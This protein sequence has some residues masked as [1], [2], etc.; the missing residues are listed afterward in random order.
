[1]CPAQT[2][3]RR[4]HGV[5]LTELIVALSIM[6]IILATGAPSMQTFIVGNRLTSQTNT[7]LGAFSIARSEAIKR[8]NLVVVA[9]TGANWEGGWNIFADLNANNTLDADE[10]ELQRYGV[11]NLNYTIRPVNNFINR[12][13]YRPDGRTTSNG[14]FD[15]CPPSGT[16]DDFREVIIA[17]TGRVRVATP[18]SAGTLIHANYAAACP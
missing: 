4:Q 1:M 14:H 13:V 12:V 11:I 10:P 16:A 17:D 7:L 6:T 2:A 5:T 8:N 9:K 18:N 3:N 15:I